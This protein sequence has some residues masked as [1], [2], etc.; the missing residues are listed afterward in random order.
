MK[1]RPHLCC[2]IFLAQVLMARP[3]KSSDR[4]QGVDPAKLASYHSRL[5]NAEN[6]LSKIE[7]SSAQSSESRTLRSAKTE[8]LDAF[9]IEQCATSLQ[10]STTKGASNQT[11]IE[12]PLLY[13]TDREYSANAAPDYYLSTRRAD[14]LDYGTVM[15]LI[16]Y[17]GQSLSQI[18]GSKLAPSSAR[19]GDKSARAPTR[20]SISAFYQAMSDYRDPRNPAPLRVLLYVHGFD[21]RHHEA[22]E[23]L[24]TL[25]VG[26]GTPVVPVFYSWPSKGQAREYWHD[27]E[28]VRT[29]YLRFLLL[30]QDL[31]ASPA[32]EI[33]VVAH[34]MG[35]RL[36][37]SA[38]GEL[39][40]RDPRSVQKLH[41]IAFAAADVSVEEFRAQWADMHKLD[42]TEWTIYESSKDLALYLS[43]IV[44]NYQ[45]VGDSDPKVLLLSGSDTVDASTTGS[46][47]QF[48][49]HSYI[50]HSAALAQDLGL[51]I[52]Q[53]LPPGSRGLARV[54]E[55]QDV[56]WKFH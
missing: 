54:S 48:L 37:V 50:T 9:E 47:F 55:G 56:Y 15:T 13:A 23:S 19:S 1:L 26:L 4:C 33:I 18:K 29:S 17:S 42:N 25:A 39:S 43:H 44:H 7:S 2:V 45:R 8:V 28:T 22:A 31:L 10:N 6:R 16:S 53:D 51:W 34:S 30:L 12:V 24:A 21:V 3:V 14:G 41:K 36:I 5:T 49:G 20:L 11:S 35:S 38:L 52:S 32:D 27:E 40:R 46:S